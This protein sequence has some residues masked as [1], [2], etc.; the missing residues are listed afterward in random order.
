MTQVEKVQSD[1]KV[2]MF[3]S[4]S[5]TDW[6]RA[7]P[8]LDL[9]SSSGCWFW[10][11]PRSLLGY[12]CWH[13]GREVSEAWARQ[14]GG[15]LT[16]TITTPDIFDMDMLAVDA[17]VLMVNV[18]T[19]SAFMSS[20]QNYLIRASHDESFRCLGAFNWVPW[21]TGKK[22]KQFLCSTSTSPLLTHLQ[23]C[24]QSACLFKAI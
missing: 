2:G 6:Q 15:T 20:Y 3:T 9:S 8:V 17:R 10:F 12:K 21:Q 24:L 22:E 18:V 5:W 13:W 11:C 23:F 4:L 7:A 1:D 19:Q 16:I 14:G